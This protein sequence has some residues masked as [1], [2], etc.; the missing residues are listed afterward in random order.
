[1][2][3]R[4][5]KS[6]EGYYH[7][8]SWGIPAVITCLLVMENRLYGTA[9]V[10]PSDR[11]W[12]W[13]STKEHQW[14]VF[15]YFY[16]PISICFVY[17]AA[18]YILLSRHVF[19]SSLGSNIRKRVL[20]YLF[21]FILCG[22]WGLINRIYQLVENHPL[23]LLTF[24]EAVFNPLCGALNAFVY[25]VSQKVF[26]RIKDKCCGCAG[27]ELLEQNTE[28]RDS[29][30]TVQQFDRPNSSDSQSTPYSR[31]R[32]AP[33]AFGSNGFGRFASGIDANIDEEVFISS[34][35]GS[36][37]MRPLLSPYA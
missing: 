31:T 16:I 37:T 33:D 18:V 28:R 15:A 36:R 12:C 13:L 25:G 34:P 26:T 1:M 5:A 3:R 22:C 30:T 23:P 14:R 4:D 24:C 21:V 6:L 17:N 7:F 20:L 11:P 35:N 8:F 27:D 10:G 19:G 9:T 2:R 32:P 29:R